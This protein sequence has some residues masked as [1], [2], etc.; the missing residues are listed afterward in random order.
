[1]R[2]D[3]RALGEV[4]GTVLHEQMGPDIFEAVENAR[5]LCIR[6][7]QRYHEDDETAIRADIEALDVD[8]L[9]ELTRAFTIYFHLINIAEEH[10]RI[11]V[12]RRREAERHP[13]PRH[14]SIEAAVQDLHLRNVPSGEVAAFLDR[15]DLW[16]VFTAHPTEARRRTVLQHFRRIAADVKLLSEEPD[17][18]AARAHFADRLA[19]HVT[20]LWQ[21]EELRAD[22]PDPLQEVRNGLY[23]FAESV[24][25]VLPTIYRDLQGALARY[26]PEVALPARPFL[27]FGSWMGGDRDGNPAVTADITEATLRLHRDTILDLYLRDV[28]GQLD[29]LS[30]SRVPHITELQ[31]S[32]EDDERSHPDIVAAARR[33]NPREPYRQ[34]LS[35]V[36]ARLQ[37]TRASEPDAIAAA[38]SSP[39]DLVADLEALQRALLAQR[40]ERIARGAIQDLLWRARAFGFHLATLDIRQESDL[41]EEIVAELLAGSCSDYRA[42]DEDARVMVLVKALQRPGSGKLS[43]LA[44]GDGVAARTAGVFTRLPDWQR[45]F[46]PDACDSYII[47]LTR[48]VSDVLEVV[49]LAKEAGLVRIDGERVEADVDIVPLLESV[50]ELETAGAMID[51]LLSIP[52]YRSLLKARRDEQE[53]M[54]GYSDSN[55]DGGYLPSNWSLYRAQ[56]AIPEAAARHGVDVR[57]FHGRGGAIGRGGGPTERA[58][59]SQPDA[60]RNGRLKLTEQGEVIFSRYS[61]PKI[62]RRYMEQVVYSMLGGGFGGSTREVEARWGELM[63]ELADAALSTYRSLVFDDPALVSFF[64]DATPILEVA[65]LKIGSRPS[66]RGAIDDVA[67]IRSIPWVFSW[68]QARMNLPGWYGLGSALLDHIQGSEDGVD[69]LR[70]M[71]STWAFFASTIDNAQISL[72]TADMRIAQRYAE[73]AGPRGDA[74]FERIRAE[75]DRTVAAVLQVTSQQDLLEGSLVARLVALR[76]P[77]V[78][79]M[80]YAQ[81]SLLR[82]LRDGHADTGATRS[83]VL[84]TINGIAAGLQTTG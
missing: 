21:T 44:Q 81:I 35:I 18:P 56:R 17:S 37:A 9:V 38:Y 4:L 69:D 83:A 68:T 52:L 19:E 25:E 66:S 46:G 63:D 48:G 40:G 29:A 43:E 51:A 16:P 39:D 41:H 32:L 2:D 72:I 80:H 27:R 60:A 45:F 49:L 50:H 7:R 62:A 26:Y 75:Y 24:Y 57:L 5:R 78:D 8:S 33:R 53:V 71:Y 6:L 1:M 77:Y 47:S 64:L 59:M 15:L 74:V 30:P 34:K 23:Y 67:R 82:R 42:L 55:K 31:S 65:R 12:L 58:I 11:R 10:H 36:L 22:R 73:L 61:N 14:E 76:N 13:A 3:V 79:P 20:V 70:E 28:A 54:L 84:Q